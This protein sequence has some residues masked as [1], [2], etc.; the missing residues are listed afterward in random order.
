MSAEQKKQTSLLREEGVRADDE[1]KLDDLLRE[2]ARAPERHVPPE[3]LQPP[4]APCVK[5]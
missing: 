4:D 2:V 1:E 5:E 3:L